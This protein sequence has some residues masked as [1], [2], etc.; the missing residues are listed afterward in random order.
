MKAAYVDTLGDAGN[1][2]FGELA[3]PVPGPGQ[4][5]VRVAAV[6]VDHVDT[7]LRSGRWRT[8]VTFPLVLGRD[9]VGTVVALGAGVSGVAVG[10][11]VWTNSA[12]YGGRPGAT[13]GLVPVDRDRLYPLPEGADPVCFVAAVHPA[14]TAHGVLTGRARLRP[15][16]TLAVTGANGAVGLC[17]V[18][19]AAGLGAPVI[20]VVRDDR[21]NRRLRELGAERVV[22]A[23]AAQALAAAAQAAPRGVDVF[24][25]PTGRV[26]LG[27]VTGLLNERGRAVLV[28]GRAPL[29]LDS[30]Q[31]YTREIAV[32][33]F[34]MS[35]MTVAEL[36][37][38]A[39]W[40]GDRYPADPV[41]VGIGPVL[42]FADARRAH[43]MLEQGLLP[44]TPD[45]L[46]GRIVLT[47]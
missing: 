32:L 45:G 4:V 44:H 39:R 46:V 28:A 23:D 8:E 14:A 5:L 12:G 7:Y 33:G 19:V 36:A 30:W 11:R 20:A 35:R 29:R 43:E 24:V 18:Q 3:D 41:V 37:A 25:D 26:D 34:V 13:A 31:L 9:L 21:S 38:A 40:I 17:L 16:E 1:I 47:P 27:P 22:V 2:R 42:P 6:A 15:G 10:A